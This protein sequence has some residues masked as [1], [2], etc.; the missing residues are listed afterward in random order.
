MFP[1]LFSIPAFEAFGRQI[2]PLTLHTYG[3]LLA[4]AFLV[5]L[6]VVARQAR[7]EG[8]DS[9][10]LTDL[11]IYTLIGG[12]IGARLLLAAV[13]WRY[14]RDHPWE[15]LSLLTS[16]GVFYGGFL[17]AIPVALW[18]MRRHRLPI[19]RTMDV[20]VPALA[21][22][23]AIGRLGCLCAGCCFGRPSSVPWAITFTS[24][25]AHRKVGTPL[26][27]EL[28]PS[29]LYESL[30]CLAIFAVLLL[31]AGRKRF[32]GQ[33][34]IAYALL[35]S[36]ARFTLE[37]FRGDEVRGFVRVTGTLLIS[38]SQL[39]SL[40]LFLAALLLLPLLMKRQRIERAPAAA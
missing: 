22:G 28:H 40:V 16:G 39:I 36:A 6:W 30:A 21:L 33:L 10:L 18:Y 8:L 23:Q 2:G 11:A 4:T 32:H 27:L 7:R 19:W 9:Q 20:L 26:D 1:S 25:E 17:A 31:L 15:I 38:T 35:Y 5:S 37:Y 12:L 34:L 13:E 14:F 29:Q 24:V 3:V